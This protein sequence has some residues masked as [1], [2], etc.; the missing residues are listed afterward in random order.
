MATLAA[1]CVTYPCDEDVLECKEGEALEVD[2]S[3]EAEGPLELQVLEMDTLAPVPADAWPTVHEGP[4]GG[5][6]FSLALRVTGLQ[7]EHL[8]FSL[9]LDALECV[10]GACEASVEL[11]H[12]TLNADAKILEEDG[13]GFVL[14]DVVVMLERAP[15][16]DGVLYVE[17]NDACGQHA[18]LQLR[19]QP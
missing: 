4:Q 13:D 7:P 19:A 2:A 16:G 1:G 17:A 9:Q 3:C 12:R 6:H 8:A 5:Q 18:R 11:G 10:D 15:E 14:P